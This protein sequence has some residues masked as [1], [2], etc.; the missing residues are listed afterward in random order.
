MSIDLEALFQAFDVTVGKPAMADAEFG[1]TF[2]RMMAA[3][4][5][6]DH[7]VV[8]AYRGNERP[9]DL[10]STFDP[11]ENVVFVTLY[12]VGPYLLDPFYHTARAR[13]PGVFRMRELAPDRFFSS[14]YYRSY[15]VQTGLAEEIGFFVT[16]DD[17]IT[18]VL[19]LMR[20]EKTGPFPPAE[21][22]LLKKA[23]PLVASLVR[24]FWPGLGA[25]FDAQRDAGLRKARKSGAAAQ[26]LQPA[27]T[28]WR[29]LK[30]T[31]RETAIVDLVLQGHSSESI[32]LRLNI[33]TGTVKVHRRNVYRKLGISSQT[34]LLSIYLKTIGS[35]GNRPAAQSTSR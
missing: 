31:S 28:V 26:G 15:Y 33:S 24:H 35:T 30:L 16:L 11:E 23:E 6:F 25:R 12:Q 18:V 29:D 14:E 9:I 10:Y 7:V 13:R 2:R 34:Q 5:R 3:L 8:F 1:E 22:A 4:V 17:D 27:D 20:R 21:F 19:S 32:G